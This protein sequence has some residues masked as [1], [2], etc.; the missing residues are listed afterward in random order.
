MEGFYNPAATAATPAASNPLL[1]QQHYHSQQQPPVSVAVPT[2]SSAI[3]TE[4][5]PRV[6]RKRKADAQDTHNERLA[7][8]MSLLNIE[9]NG[10]RLYV[11]VEQRQL[12][13]ESTQPASASASASLGTGTPSSSSHPVVSPIED[14]QMHLDDSKHKVY[15]YN[16]DDELSDT[17]SDPE[18]EQGRL[19]FLPDIE[20]HLRANRFN[21]LPLLKPILPNKDGELAGMQLV[22]YSDGPTSITVPEEQDSVRKAVLEARARVRQRQ[23]EEKEGNPATTQQRPRP[24]KATFAT[25]VRP[26]APAQQAETQPLVDMML[27]QPAVARSST[28][29]DQSEDD[30][31]DAMDID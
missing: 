3:P 13:R 19:A 7:K 8:R 11:P 30:D 28:S 9:Q 21:P 1:D 16:L 4:A 2:S 5:P 6:R 15:I 24:T 25:P 17:E 26:M 22:L 23:A 14:D 18:L 31:P 27:D 10:T 12:P 29:V 20:K